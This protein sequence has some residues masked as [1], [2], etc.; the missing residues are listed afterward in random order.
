MTAGVL[1]YFSRM[2]GSFIGG[3]IYTSNQRA[4]WL[5]FGMAFILCFLFGLRFIRE[6]E[7]KEI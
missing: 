6:A 7:R 4:P 2:I 3:F 1:L 5:I